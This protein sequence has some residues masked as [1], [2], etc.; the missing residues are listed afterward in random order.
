MIL[1]TD[2]WHPRMQIKVKGK[3]PYQY[4]RFLVTDI[5]RIIIYLRPVRDSPLQAKE[6][7]YLTFSFG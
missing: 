2:R 7:L 4:G 6:K 1:T 3:T 5:I